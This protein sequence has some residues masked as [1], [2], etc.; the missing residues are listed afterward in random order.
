MPFST[1]GMNSDGT[2]AL[3]A[4]HEVE[5]LTGC[6]LRVYVD[7]HAAGAARRRTDTLDV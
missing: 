6:R 4:I 5:A 1:A 3:D 7:R 2:A